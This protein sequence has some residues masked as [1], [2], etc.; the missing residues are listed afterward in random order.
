MF[1]KIKRYKINQMAVAVL[2]VFIIIFLYFNYPNVFNIN[3]K[4]IDGK[5]V[6]LERIN[7]YDP[8]N[9]ANFIIDDND[10]NVIV[11][12]AANVNPNIAFGD[13]KTPKAKA[14][15]AT[16][17]VLIETTS[18]TYSQPFVEFDLGGLKKVSKV[19]IVNRNKYNTRMS[20][21]L[22]R[23]LDEHRDIVFEEMILDTKNI[24]SI[25]IF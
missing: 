19:T 16:D 7:G 20:G 1:F 14:G 3:T 2:F 11:P 17:I 22:L 25:N 12:V 6:R 4:F 9:F 18:N 8:I 21:T 13:G 24:Y 23:I 15:N 10:G 5:Y